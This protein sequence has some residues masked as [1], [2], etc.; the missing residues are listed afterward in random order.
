MISKKVSDRSHF[1]LN[2]ESLLYTTW[3]N[4][5]IHNKD[6]GSAFFREQMEVD[7][8]TTAGTDQMRIPN[9]MLPSQDKD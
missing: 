3:Q 8:P 6:Y 1:G 2:I 9:K 7:P 4:A 5:L